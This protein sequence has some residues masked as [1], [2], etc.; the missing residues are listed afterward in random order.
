M[1]AV[2]IE[3]EPLAV[4]NLKYYLK[5]YPIEI[6]GSAYRINEAAKL[7]K[8]ENPEIVF[9]DI[10]L[11]GEDGFD[12]LEKIEINFKLV[13]VTAY[14]EF[15]VRAFEVNALDYIMKPLSKKRIDKTIQRLFKNPN[16]ENTNR[17]DINDVIFLSSDERASFVKVRDI[18]YIEADSSYSN[19]YLSDETFKVAS[20]TLK[21]WESILPENEFLR[22]HRSFLLNINYIDK[23]HKRRNGT[24]KVVVSKSKNSIDISR[25]CAASLR[26]RL[27]I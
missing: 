1:K 27:N 14:N 22:V 21:K 19:L 23:V 4:E 2:I 20:K 8:K 7:I 5:D 6:V 18:V 17:Y 26:T 24:F 25:R 12:L 13:F 10:N 16:L 9:L 11:S 3:D 15:A